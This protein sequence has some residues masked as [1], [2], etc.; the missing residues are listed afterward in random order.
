MKHEFSEM[1]VLGATSLMLILFM[2]MLK[3]MGGAK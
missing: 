3:F 1:S 2:S